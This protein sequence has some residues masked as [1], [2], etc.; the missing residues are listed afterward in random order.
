[1]PLDYRP[2]PAEPSARFMARVMA[3][4]NAKR[5]PFDLVNAVLPRMAETVSPEAVGNL[6]KASQDLLEALGVTSDRANLL[7]EAVAAV[8]DGAGGDDP[9]VK[10]EARVLAELSDRITAK[11]R[12][13]SPMAS[14]TFRGPSSHIIR[15]ERDT[16]RAGMT[17]ALVARMSRARDVQGPARQFMGATL[18]EMAALA[19]GDR[20]MPRSAGDKLRAFEIAMSTHSRSDFPAIFENALN[21]RLIDGYNAAP[22]KF[23]AV[24][25]RRDFT[26]FRPHPM[27]GVGDWP[28]LETV[29]EGGEI[30]YGTFSESK[31]TVALIAYAKAMRIS[32]QMIVDD[33]L[34]AIDR[35]LS[36]RGRAVAAFEDMVFFSMFL[37]G[38]NADGPT[39][40]TTTRQVF[41]TTDLSK[42]SSNSVINSANLTIAR[43]A[44]RKRKSLDGN[45]IDVQPAIL[46]V[47][48]DKETEAEKALTEIQA[49]TV[50]EANP[51]GGKLVLVVT[52]KIPGNAWYVFADPAAA[53]CFVHGYLEGEEGPRMRMDEPFGQQGIAYSVELDFGCGAVDFRGGFKNAG[54]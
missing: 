30:K 39:L 7:A 23:Q 44:I 46:L 40:L 11:K 27:V 41:N 31:E 26:D 3:V 10:P 34:G 54:A 1:M 18:A 6:V 14:M 38:A 33:N 42:A 13:E 47:G 51:F 50:A 35:L 19:N 25:D 53:P 28:M 49:N 2:K 48:P 15:D 21:K 22:P 9:E 45:D 24:S 16:M 20:Q 36:Q 52:P 43:A 4:A 17:G 29:G 32:R 37:S 12:A 5:L 8:A